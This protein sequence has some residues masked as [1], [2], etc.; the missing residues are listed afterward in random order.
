MQTATTRKWELRS[1]LISDKVDS[2]MKTVTKDREGH[3]VLKKVPKH[4]ET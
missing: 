1:T 4:Q 2:K 3:F